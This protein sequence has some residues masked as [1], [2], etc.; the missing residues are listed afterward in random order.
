MSEEVKEKLKEQGV[1]VTIL[2]TWH[3]FLV[4][5]G[6]LVSLGIIW[7]VTTSRIG[8]IEKD[9]ASHDN[10]IK[11]HEE[12]VSKLGEGHVKLFYELQLNLRR[13][14]EKNGITYQEMKQDT[15][16]N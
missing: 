14:C 12:K 8:E 4:V 6:M 1:I 2:Q 5:I 3:I 7:G 9:V 11:S 10:W 15:N 13:L 16:A